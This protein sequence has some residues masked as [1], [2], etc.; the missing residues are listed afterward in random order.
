MSL[1]PP[2]SVISGDAQQ[3]ASLSA[4]LPRRRRH[5]SHLSDKEAPSQPPTTTTTTEPPQSSSWFSLERIPVPTGIHH[6][7]RAPRRT[8][9]RI[10]SQQ[11]EVDPKLGG[12]NGEEILNGGGLGGGEQP[13][14]KMMEIRWMISSNDSR[15]QRED[16][17]G[18]CDLGALR[19]SVL[20]LTW[21]PG[22]IHENVYRFLTPQKTNASR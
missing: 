17:R 2:S 7:T 3:G 21:P 10:K 15:T 12:D 18:S 19:P 13:C 4:R 14:G 20:A 8:G 9:E 5:L 16:P 22:W 1:T 6:A 11:E